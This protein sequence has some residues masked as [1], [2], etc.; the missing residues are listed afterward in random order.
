MN[1]PSIF[2]LKS[3]DR[4][5]ILGESEQ[6]TTIGKGNGERAGVYFLTPHPRADSSFV[7]FP[8]SFTKLPKLANLTAQ[9]LGAKNRGSFHSL[10]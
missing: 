9:P 5:G 6:K 10:E 1:S 4:L 2:A 3:F 8:V 7:L